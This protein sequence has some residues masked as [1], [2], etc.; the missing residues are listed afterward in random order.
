MPRINTIMKYNACINAYIVTVRFNNE[1]TETGCTPQLSQANTDISDCVRRIPA[2]MQ[3]FAEYIEALAICKTR[4]HVHVH[5]YY[6]LCMYAQGK[7]TFIIFLTL[8]IHL[9]YSS[10]KLLIILHVFYM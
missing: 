10:F 6:M 9:F 7:P 2:L 3:S 5:V 8:H 4:I 1:S